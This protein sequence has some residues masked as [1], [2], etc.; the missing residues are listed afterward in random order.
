MKICLSADRFH[1]RFL[2]IA[3][4][5]KPYATVDT[6]GLDGFS[7]KGYDLF[8]GKKLSEEKLRTADRLKAVF[9]YK[10]GV[11]DFP[12]AALSERGIP[13]Y[14]SH[15]NSDVIAEF[16][17]ALCLSLTARIPYYDT[18]MRRGDWAGDD[19][20]W[21]S[22]FSM[23]VGLAGFGSIGK[24]VHALFKR[25][26]VETYT[27]DRGK[28]YEEI[29]VV[30][31]LKELC[32]TC[33][34]IVASLPKTAET[35][36]IFNAELF[37]LMKGKYF[38]NVGRGSCVDE[39]ALYF[40]LTEGGMA[41]AAI[42]T[43]RIKPEH[44]KV[45]FYPYSRPFHELKNVVLSSHKAMQVTDGFKRYADDTVQNVLRFLRGEPMPPA[46]DCK[47]GY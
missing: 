7:L 18:M 37:S 29:K 28:D 10:T 22:L 30:P 40:A 25:I 46:V 34:I 20:S 1:A 3:D 12:L 39:D 47:K 26:G 27:V 42:D 36:N 32:S 2:E 11:D 19:P 35:E 14:N 38:V 24:A 4:K 31:S 8:I 21:K 13:L 41:G 43:W 15:I 23:K 5:L 44:D 45:A 9:S 6:V 16:T 17:L 33:D